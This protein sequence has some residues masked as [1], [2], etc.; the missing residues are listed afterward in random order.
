MR[1]VVVACS[2]FVSIDAAAASPPA[3]G[4]GGQ[5]PAAG[6]QQQ[7]QALTRN[8]GRGPLIIPKGA[9]QRK[10][11]SSASARRG[12]IDSAGQGAAAQLAATI[13]LSS[14]AGS[15]RPLR[16]DSATR[17]IRVWIAVPSPFPVARDQEKPES[18]QMQSGPGNT[19]RTLAARPIADGRIQGAGHFTSPQWTDTRQDR[20]EGTK[21]AL[22]TV[23]RYRA[24]ERPEWAKGTAQSS[25]EEEDEEQAPAIERGP[26]HRLG[27]L[28][29]RERDVRGPE[30]VRRRR[31]REESDEEEERERPAP[32]GRGR[33]QEDDQE[34]EEDEDAI[35]RRREMARLRCASILSKTP[36][37]LRL[38]VNETHERHQPAAARHLVADASRW[39]SRKSSRKKRMWR[40]RKR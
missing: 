5:G 31:E 11:A 6:A 27:R 36:R 18:F 19:G 8:A 33:A 21:A 16:D 20:G 32:S 26:D 40:R 2:I 38:S 17:V 14:P 22:T 10:G 9:P 13:K 35:E 7:Q 23:K 25:E 39:R 3:G 1:R 37:C 29:A 34:E 30:V 24:G 15:Q 4:G 28:A 12:Y